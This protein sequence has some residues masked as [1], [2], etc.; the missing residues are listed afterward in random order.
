MRCSASAGTAQLPS[1]LQ[2]LVTA[3]Q[4]VP[5]PMAVR[6]AAAAAAC[7]PPAP[8]LQLCRLPAG[9][10]VQPQCLLNCAAGAVGAARQLPRL[11]MRLPIAPCSRRTSAPAHPPAAAPPLAAPA[12]PSSQRYKQLLFYATKLEPFPVE[13]H[14]EENKVKGCVSQVRA[15][16][17]PRSRARPTS[18][19]RAGHAAAGRP[20]GRAALLRR[21]PGGLLGPVRLLRLLCCLVATAAQSLAQLLPH[22]RP[23]P[24][25]AGKPAPAVNP[26]RACPRCGC[27]RSCGTGAC[28]GRPTRTRS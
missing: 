26:A 27:W 15:A 19:L 12:R 16:E 3:F 11:A 18:Q 28:T 22:Q 10:S 13:A 7:S 24:S 2:S 25:P 23:V 8:E 9:C 17:A 21:C 5:D 4:A 1:S 20:G 6:A 14:S